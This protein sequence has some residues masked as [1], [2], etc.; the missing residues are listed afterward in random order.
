MQGLISKAVDPL[1]SSLGNFGQLASGVF[2]KLMSPL[3]DWFTKGLKKVQ[4]EGQGAPA[5]AGVQRWAD[6]VKQALSANGLSTSDG[7]VQKVLRQIQTESGGNEKAVQGGYTDVNTISGDLAK[8]L[9]QTISAT[10]NAYAFP[11]HHNIFN[12]YDNLLAAL[13]YAKNRYG[14]NLSYLGQ[15]HGYANGGLITQ[16]QIAEIGE[17]NKPEMII[18]LDGMK[19]SRGFELLGKTAVAMAARDGFGS[20]NVVKN[21]NSDVVSE[22]KAAVALLTQL[23]IGQQENKTTNVV[24][25]KNALYKQQAIDT[26]LR[27][28]QSLA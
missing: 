18:P 16:H 22:L 28:Y 17:G 11:G 2:D 7:M 10:F 25:D 3:S 15:G 26:N 5:G 9:M 1:I 27:N 23:V 14:S 13:A 4:D 8:G 19:S 21:D 24:L 20:Q 12:G 6:Q